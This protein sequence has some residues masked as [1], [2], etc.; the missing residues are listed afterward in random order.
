MQVLPT[1]RGGKA[2]PVLG[3]GGGTTKDVLI[4]RH[5]RDKPPREGAPVVI[6]ESRQVRSPTLY[7]GRFDE[8]VALEGSYE[9]VANEAETTELEE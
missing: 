7:R 4:G 2:Q 3:F 9:L 8:Q 1:V 6:S 5:D